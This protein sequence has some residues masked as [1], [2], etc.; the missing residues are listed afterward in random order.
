MSVVCSR[1]SGGGFMTIKRV[2][3][4]A[5]QVPRY[6]ASVEIYCGL[7]HNP[8][9]RDAFLNSRSVV[10]TLCFGRSGGHCTETCPSSFHRCF[11]CDVWPVN[12]PAAN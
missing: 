9:I 7:G 12:I 6:E 3:K 5:T 8:S 2:Y 1:G 11:N 10:C 4:A